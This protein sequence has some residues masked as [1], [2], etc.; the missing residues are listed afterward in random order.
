MKAV[1]RL[2]GSPLLFGNS[3]NRGESFRVLLTMYWAALRL[4]TSTFVQGVLD[5]STL[6]LDMTGHYGDTVEEG[7]WPH[8]TYR[9][10]CW[11]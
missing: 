11:C 2:H 10:C 5:T 8:H 4:L 1:S 9:R 6:H 3:A 7:E